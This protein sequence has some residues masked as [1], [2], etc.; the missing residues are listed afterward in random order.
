MRKSSEQI[1]LLHAERWKEFAPLSDVERGDILRAAIGYA[2][3]GDN[4]GIGRLREKYESKMNDGPDKRAFEI[5]TA[6]HQAKSEEF[7]ELTKAVGA[8]DTLEFLPARHARPLSGDR[9]A[10]AGREPDADP[11][12]GPARTGRSGA[13]RIRAAAGLVDAA[14]ALE[15]DAEKCEAVSRLREARFGGRRKVGQHHAL[16]D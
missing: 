16:N 7:R 13:Y 3:A 2:L 5:A 4:I 15:H 6:P 14:A 10:V 9:H 8:H 11:E 12:A 1:E